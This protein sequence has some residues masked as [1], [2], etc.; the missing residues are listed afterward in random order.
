V[1]YRVMYLWPRMEGGFYRAA[2]GRLSP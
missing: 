1:S 2:M